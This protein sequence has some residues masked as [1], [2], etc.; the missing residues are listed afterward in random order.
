MKNKG[1]IYA[2]NYD[3]LQIRGMRELIRRTSVK[4]IRTFEK[5]VNSAPE[6]LSEEVFLSTFII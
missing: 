5:D 4:I 1:I 2:F 3:K 6:F